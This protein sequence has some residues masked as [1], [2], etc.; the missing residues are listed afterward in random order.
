MERWNG[1]DTW[2]CGCEC[3]CLCVW[4]CVLVCVCAFVCVCLCVCL[5]VCVC[6]LARHAQRASEREIVT[7]CFACLKTFQNSCLHR[8]GC[9][10]SRFLQSPHAAPEGLPSHPASLRDCAFYPGAA[11]SFAFI[12]RFP[13]VFNVVLCFMASPSKIAL[14]TLYLLNIYIPL[15]WLSKIGLSVS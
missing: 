11:A 3:V 4:V 9:L 13:P 1:V 8:A 12:L 14:A 15:A 2:V 10:C 6:V 7:P 5:S